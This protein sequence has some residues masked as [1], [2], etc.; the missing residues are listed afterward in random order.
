MV[1]Y[2]AG[3]IVFQWRYYAAVL[4][5]FSLCAVIHSI[6]HDE[7]QYVA[8]A[9]LTAH[10]FL[11]FRDFAYLQ[12]PLQPF[13]FAPV[14]WIAGPWVWPVLRLINALLGT[15]IVLCVWRAA[16]EAGASSRAALTAAGLLSV[17]DI[18]LFS[19]GTARNDALPAALLAAALVLIVRAQQGRGSFGAA[20]LVGLLLAGAAAAKVS[21]ALPAAAYGVYAL[22]DRRHHRPLALFAGAVPMLAFIVW[23]WAIAP[24]AFVFGTL[25]FPAL[26]PAEYYASRPWKMS[27]AAKGIDAI[28]FFALGPALVALVA[29]RRRLARP[30][31]IEGML[32]AG[33]AAALLPF[34]TWRQYLLPV[35]PP[36]FVLLALE[37]DRA[38]PARAMRIVTAVT[39]FAGLAPTV[40]TAVLTLKGASM[41]VALREGTAIRAGLDAAQVRGSVATLSPQF[42]GRTGRL[43]DPRF[44]AGP[45]YFRTHRVIDPAAESK[46][47]IVSA[48]R[49][50]DLERNPPAA[51]LIGGEAPWTAGDS[52]T[53]A[54]LEAWATSHGYRPIAIRSARFRLYVRRP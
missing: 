1:E 21:Y 43:P 42:L 53:D 4:A 31:A 32:I 11:P 28:K 6:D 51:I 8:A 16:R 48:D 30:A 29:V 27:F 23:T 18:L 19:I 46:F 3:P 17:C 33:L 20:M 45:F 34:P 13:L 35:L 25:R 36:L 10:G 54:L 14:V 26:A 24:D 9:V 41:P 40:A 39:V 47:H 50:S 38:P 37:W 15:G 2:E 52:D 44:A 22:V 5:F 12:T 7:S 49:T